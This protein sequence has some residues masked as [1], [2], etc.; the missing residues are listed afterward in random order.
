ML[1]NLAAT[2]RAFN[3]SNIRQEVKAK[4]ELMAEMVAKYYYCG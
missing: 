3:D 4:P 2:L 1:T